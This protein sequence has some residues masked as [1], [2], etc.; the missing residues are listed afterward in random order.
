MRRI[1]WWARR[2]LRLDD[3]I[4]LHHALNDGAA[5]IPVFVL[6]PKLLNSEKL[7][8]ARRQF[9]FEAL[10]ELD[11]N[12]KARGSYLVVREGEAASELVKLARETQADAVYFH[13]DYTPYARRRDAKVTTALGEAGIRHAS[14]ND[15]YLADPNQVVKEDGSPY[16]VYSRYRAR[17]GTLVAVPERY[18]TSQALNTPPGI[19]SLAL[20]RARRNENYARGGEREGIELAREFVARRNG[21]AEY[22]ER[23]NDMA[24]DATSHLSPHLH[25]GTVSVRDLVRMAR[26]A[27]PRM[28]RQGNRAG[29]AGA[30]NAKIWVDE[31]VW[32]EFLAHVLYHYPR[33][34]R[35]SFRAEYAELPWEKDE[36]LIAAWR[37]GETGYPIVDAGMRQLNKSGWM[38]NRARMITASFL[39]KDLLSDWREGERY[40]LQ[41]LIDGDMASNNGGWQW[42]A[43]TGTDAQPYFRIFNPVL[44]GARFDPAGEY[45]RRW[46]PELAKVPAEFIHAPWEMPDDVARRIGFALGKDYPKPIVNHAVRR[47]RALEL[48][49]SRAR[50]GDATP[51]RRKREPHLE[52]S[53]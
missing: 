46:V 19:P 17:F 22:G 43:G 45:V 23:R 47:E 13:A 20:P 44:Q 52:M 16:T 35:E 49:R 8:P 34:A 50:R 2:D 29:R 15:L 27:H 14:F 25:F 28:D 38:H 32:R 48:Y 3:N 24:A 10:R 53:L 6:D 39:T 40:F 4:V 1:L 21:L 7:A 11:V 37:R 12:L 33:A 36:A 30:E 26:K 9:L 5:V 41:H 42:S 18:S 31:L 51:V